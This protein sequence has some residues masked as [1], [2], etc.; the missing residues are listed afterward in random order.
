MHEGTRSE[1]VLVAGAE[2]GFEDCAAVMVL[3]GR[4]RV[5]V[6]D[7]T[8][9]TI[10]PGELIAPG[11]TGPSKGYA[12]VADTPMTVLDLDRGAVAALLHEPAVAAAILRAAAAGLGRV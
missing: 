12:V 6:S 3:A 2:L 8:A 11:L 10:G 7:H 5:R 4:A 1:R 9:L